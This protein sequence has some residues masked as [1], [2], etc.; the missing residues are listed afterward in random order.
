MRA[1]IF[2][3]LLFVLAG[4]QDYYSTP[5]CE[6][7]QSFP[8]FA[9]T[10]RGADGNPVVVKEVKPGVYQM[11]GQTEVVTTCLA[12]SKW[13]MEFS[14]NVNSN[15]GKSHYV[16]MAIAWT[17]VKTGPVEGMKGDQNYRELVWAGTKFDRVKI[18]QSGLPYKATDL[19][20]GEQVLVIDNS[21]SSINIG[22]F[23]EMSDIDWTQ[24]TNRQ[25]GP[26]LFIDVL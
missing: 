11:N 22:N 24:M 6:Y 21:K 15:K 5:I 17:G 25:L 4:C 16:N 12:N 1:I 7:P 26:V 14:L 13:V 3:S 20:Q 8:A 18:Q 2:V 9:G 10:H 19:G 23:L